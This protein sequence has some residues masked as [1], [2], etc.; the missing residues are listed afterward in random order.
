[1]FQLDN[2]IFK[3]EL[4]LCFNLFGYRLLNGRK[5]TIVNDAIDLSSGISKRWSIKRRSDFD[6]YFLLFSI[7]FSLKY[8][9]KPTSIDSIIVENAERPFVTLV[10]P[11]V[12][13]SRSWALNSRSE[14]A[15]IVFLPS[16][17]KSKFG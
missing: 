17:M 7:V 15:M 10:Q 14:Y 9:F 12:A 1:M 16:Q 6:K 8:S 2:F 11:I 4:T 13:P 5:A 3:V